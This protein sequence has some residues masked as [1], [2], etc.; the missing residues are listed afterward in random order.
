MVE[1]VSASMV[2]MVLG[3][4]LLYSFS[5]TLALHEKQ[6]FLLN[7]FLVNVNKFALLRAYELMNISKN[8][9]PGPGTF[10]KTQDSRTEINLTGLT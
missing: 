10:G 5:E 8:W 1:I 9:D 4:F 6:S 7:I 2:I 3:I